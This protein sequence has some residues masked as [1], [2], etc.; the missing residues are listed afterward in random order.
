LLFTYIFNVIVLRSSDQGNPF[1]DHNDEG[2]FVMA[3]KKFARGEIRGTVI[4]IMKKHRITPKTPFDSDS[5]VKAR[6]AAEKKLPDHNVPSIMAFVRR[7]PGMLGGKAVAR[8]STSKSST[9]NA[10]KSAKS[11][12]K[13]K[14]V[15][16]SAAPAPETTE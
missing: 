11:K 16:K 13:V 3:A 14:S 12:T 5:Y 6:A 1:F 2:G 15:K 9:S 4:E 7:T 8:K 10:R